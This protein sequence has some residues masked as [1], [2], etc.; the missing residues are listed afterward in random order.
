MRASWF[1]IDDGRAK[2]PWKEWKACVADT[3][4]LKASVAL[5]MRVFQICMG[6]L[7]PPMPR[8]ARAQIE[9]YAHALHHGFDE[10]DDRTLQ[11]LVLSFEGRGGLVEPRFWEDPRHRLAQHLSLNQAPYRGGGLARIELLALEDDL[12]HNVRLN[13]LRL[14]WILEMGAGMVSPYSKSQSDD[15]HSPR[16]ISDALSEISQLLDG[17]LPEFLDEREVKSL[18]GMISGLRRLGAPE[19]GPEALVSLSQRCDVGVSAEGR[20]VLLS[21]AFKA[22]DLSAKDARSW[23]RSCFLYGSLMTSFKIMML[24]H[25]S[26]RTDGLRPVSALL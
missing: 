9:A 21:A 26:G 19:L 25:V 5:G 22:G 8:H 20:A 4:D 23:R 1:K 14:A 2:A 3:E 15:W 6:P 11:E 17:G 24:A 12:D 13:L 16:K 7:V 10:V 18:R